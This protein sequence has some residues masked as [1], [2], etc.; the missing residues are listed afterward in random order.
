M[1][2]ENLVAVALA[3]VD[4]ADQQFR[5]QGA[6]ELGTIEGSLRPRRRRHRR[7]CAASCRSEHRARVSTRHRRRW[8]GTPAGGPVRCSRTAWVKD[9]PASQR[10]GPRLLQRAHI[11][12]VGGVGPVALVLHLEGL[13]FHGAGGPETGRDLVRQGPD[14][15]DRAARIDV[16]RERRE[17]LAAVL[18]HHLHGLACH[19]VDRVQHDE[20]GAVGQHVDVRA[21]LAP[22]RTAT[23]R[24]CP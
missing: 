21:R 11:G 8:T 10:I 15:G 22:R 23:R 4:L 17:L 18:V 24:S 7:R 13:A 14:A 6:D 20:A 3:Q 19:A 2:G 1:T 16:K 12:L 5:P 9:F